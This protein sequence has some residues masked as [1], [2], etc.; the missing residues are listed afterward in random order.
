MKKYLI[1]FALFIT[2]S[3]G[4]ANPTQHVIIFG[5]S[6]ADAAPLNSPQAEAKGNNNWIPFCFPN[7]S[8]CQKP[9][10]TGTPI[11]DRTNKYSSLFPTGLRINW[12]NFF[13]AKYFA[14]GYLVTYRQIV[15][16]RKTDPTAYA[17]INDYNVDF[18]YGSAE[19]G[20][21]YTD[22]L[23]GYAPTMAYNPYVPN[24]T[25]TQPCTAP[26]WHHDPN[27]P[28]ATATSCVP[29][30]AQ[31][32]QEYLSLVQQ[33]ADPDNI[34]VIWAGA[35]DIFSNIGKLLT[36][37]DEHKYLTIATTLPKLLYNCS[38]LTSPTYVKVG[39][40]E[41]SCP[42][43]NLVLDV[44][45]LINS[46]ASAKNIYVIALPD[47]S[48][49]PAASQYPKI[50]TKYLISKRTNDNL[51]KKLNAL[52]KKRNI[53][54][55]NVYP[56]DK[57][58]DQIA[59]NANQYGFT[60]TSDSCV[61]KNGNEDPAVNNCNDYVFYNGKHPTGHAG[62]C[63]ASGISNYFSCKAKHGTNCENTSYEPFDA[64]CDLAPISH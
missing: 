58:F 55:V 10:L 3:L 19:T 59:K 38:I 36:L 54:N 33:K 31:Q 17:D 57:A 1:I 49:A 22:D 62:Q 50:L 14:K 41:F 9:Y 43:N 15:D 18:A 5:A 37:A 21:K 2:P 25:T 24:D 4:F 45:T 63:I 26:G 32:I 20:N 42:V 12:S 51:I 39:N 11:S 30:V 64:K 60:D 13:T 52:S 47:L 53:P 6:L 40:M 29:G 27:N 61:A 35:N 44:Q 23:H 8:V 48:L 16:A 7:T 28:L 46:G 34:Y 56:T